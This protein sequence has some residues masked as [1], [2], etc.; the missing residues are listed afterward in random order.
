MSAERNDAPADD[1]ARGSKAKEQ[2]STPLG[3]ASLCSTSDVA[4]IHRD[5]LAPLPAQ[6]DAAIDDVKTNAAGMVRAAVRAGQ[7]LQRA[8]VAVPHGEWDAWL[9]TNCTVAPRTA[10]AYMRLCT[11]LGEL[12][13]EMRNAVADLPLREAMKAITTTPSAPRRSTYLRLNDTERAVS[14]LRGCCYA[15][16]QSARELSQAGRVKRSKIEQTR[17]K[18]Q[19]AM[20]ELD[21]L[22]VACEREG[23]Q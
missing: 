7:L 16:Q 13:A 3:A 18:L 22:L 5:D 6:I 12:P 8:K 1:A 11:K 4:V 17:A 15:V 10:Q 9:R 21:K 2:E 14:A 19:A 23:N 20:A